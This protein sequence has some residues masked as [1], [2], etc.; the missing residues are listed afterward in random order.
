MSNKPD[1]V[2]SNESESTHS[3]YAAKTFVGRSIENAPGAFG[4][5]TEDGAWMVGRGATPERALQDL[6]RVV[7]EAYL[8]LMERP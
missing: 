4:A 2:I 8:S 3:R 7:G 5:M 1:I 6:Y